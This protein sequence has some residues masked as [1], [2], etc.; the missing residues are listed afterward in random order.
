MYITVMCFHR[1]CWFSG[2][3]DY[4]ETGNNDEIIKIITDSEMSSKNY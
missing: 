4:M 3:L 2:G 1:S